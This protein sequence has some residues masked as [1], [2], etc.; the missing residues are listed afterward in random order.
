M[1]PLPEQSV[2][3]NSSQLTAEKFEEI[4][5]KLSTENL[6]E[7]PSSFQMARNLLK[8]AWTTSIDVARGQPLLT[9]AEKAAARMDICKGCEFFRAPR[10]TK[11]GCYM[12]KKVHLESSQCPTNKWGA[13]LQK[14]YP[15]E[16]AQKNLESP[17]RTMPN[18]DIYKE[19][20][21]EDADAIDKLATDALQFDGRF[22]WKGMQFKVEVLHG[23]RSISQLQPRNPGG[24][25]TSLPNH[26]NLTIEEQVEFNQLAT[27]HQ[28]PDQPKVFVY[29]TQ[30]FL[31]TP[32]TGKDA[33]P[34]QFMLNV[35]DPNNP[36]PGVSIPPIT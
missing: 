20:P 10:C 25:T 27:K 31:L 33:K 14:L 17:H 30:T 34:N 22:A 5:G 11:C 32:R 24:V 29:K 26:K 13:E 6:S 8:Q 12:D 16:I 4:K 2:N 1:N 9:T 19:F 28:A 15:A 7:F 21:K 3:A 36:P 23:Q 35:I 18:L